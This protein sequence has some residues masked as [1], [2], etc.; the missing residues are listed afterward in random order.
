MN[1]SL[2]SMI[3]PARSTHMPNGQ[4]DPAPISN[5]IS[6]MIGRSFLVPAVNIARHTPIIHQCPRSIVRAVSR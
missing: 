5:A 4:T 3:V 6:N 1:A 2:R